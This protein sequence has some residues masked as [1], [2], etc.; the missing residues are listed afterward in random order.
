MKAAFADTGDKVAH[1]AKSKASKLASRHHRRKRRREQRVEEAPPYPTYSQPDAGCDVATNNEKTST[2]QGISVPP[3]SSSRDENAGDGVSSNEEYSCGGGVGSGARPSPKV[4]SVGQTGLENELRPKS[5]DE[6]EVNHPNSSFEEMKESMTF[7]IVQAPSTIASMEQQAQGGHLPLSRISCKKVCEAGD[8]PNENRGRRNG[9]VGYTEERKLES[10]ITKTAEGDL[11]RQQAV[12]TKVKKVGMDIIEIDCSEDDRSSEE[13]LLKASRKSRIVE[14]KASNRKKKANS[15]ARKRPKPARVGKETSDVAGNRCKDETEQ[16]RK[17]TKSEIGARTQAKL[18]PGEKN[19]C[20]ACLTCDCCNRDATAKT[21]TKGTSRDFCSDAR[22]EQSLL[23][24]INKHNRH[25]DWCVSTRDKTYRDLKRHRREIQKKKGSSANSIDEGA[26]RDRF[27]ADAESTNDLESKVSRAIG[28]AEIKRA[29]RLIFGG[30]PKTQQATMTQLFRTSSSDNDSTASQTCGAT[31]DATFE[32]ALVDGKPS[33]G[34][35]ND[36]LFTIQ[37]Y[38]H[39]TCWDDLVHYEDNGAYGSMN[40]LKGARLKRNSCWAKSTAS[41]FQQEDGEEGFDALVDLFDST[42]ASNHADTSDLCTQADGDASCTESMPASPSDRKI[43]VELVSSVSRDPDRKAAVER[44][45]PNWKRNIHQSLL[46]ND[47][48][49]MV[50]ALKRV[51][52]ARCDLASMR[53]RMLQAFDDRAQTL[54]LFEKSIQAS[55]N[56]TD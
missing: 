6:S 28:F 39:L 37:Q 17:R 12:R 13:P 36:C 35:V 41:Q 43:A 24:R 31:T 20:H 54:E 34:A 1:G 21:P 56:R 18:A 19:R 38:D 48:K 3:S 52:Q 33:S 49:E 47:P 51:K 40:D 11:R 7:G 55:I 8:D 4:A 14:Q 42:I 29:N 2:D 44:V 46:Y 26:Q 25:I 9:E 53:I 27:L 23:N 45:C 16:G 30:K 15:Q 10:H 32:K 22:I 5:S 50:S